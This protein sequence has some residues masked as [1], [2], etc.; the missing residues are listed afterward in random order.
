MLSAMSRPSPRFI[1]R[2]LVVVLVA[3]ASLLASCSS[4]D[5]KSSVPVPDRY[6][7][8]CELAAKAKTTDP[9]QSLALLDKQIEVAP[10]E[11]AADLKAVRKWQ[12]L[13]ADKDADALELAGARQDGLPAFARV[14]KFLDAECGVTVNLFEK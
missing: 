11:I 7:K 9:E 2:S 5:D 13:Q 4:G 12:A 1:G 10:E 14:V 6:K 8:Y 3:T